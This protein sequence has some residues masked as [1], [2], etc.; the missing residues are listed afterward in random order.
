MCRVSVVLSVTKPAFNFR[1]KTGKWTH[2]AQSP[3]LH[4][5]PALQLGLRMMV[6]GRIA[7]GQA[8]WKQV[9]IVVMVNVT[10]TK[11]V[12]S[13]MAEKT[14]GLQKV[15]YFHWGLKWRTTV[16][17]RELWCLVTASCT[18]LAWCEHACWDTPDWSVCSLQ[19]PVACYCLKWHWSVFVLY[20]PEAR[21][22]WL[23]CS[24]VLPA[25][26]LCEYIWIYW[27]EV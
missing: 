1:G 5:D 18:D 21:H 14:N 20:L 17:I 12:F 13:A 24:L 10:S 6:Q 4:W 11:S 27:L 19:A 26:S 3:Y 2:T 16:K 22:G 25:V 9:R 8:S 15:G 23:S 7:G